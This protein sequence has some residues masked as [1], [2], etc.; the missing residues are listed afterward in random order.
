MK[1]KKQASPIRKIKPMSELTHPPIW[2]VVVAAGVGSRMQADVPKQYLP[3]AG[4]SVLDVTL[5]RLLSFERASGV[6]LVLNPKD[7]LWSSSEFSGDSRVRRVDGGATRADSVLAGLSY[8]N[9]AIESSGSA[10]ALVHDAARPCVTEAKLKYLVESCLARA[11][12]GILAVPATDTVKRAN[13]DDTIAKTEARSE[14]W[15]A[16][17]P[18][19]FPAKELEDAIREALSQNAEITDEA[20]AMEFVSKPVHLIEDEHNN[21][22][23]TRPSDLALAEWI[24]LQQQKTHSV[25]PNR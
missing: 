9:S 24:I 11:E 20:S 23:I 6:V 2:F 18:Q 16:H 10:W 13:S 8:L 4:K 3:L 22:K 17:T 25:G 21:I 14:L 1:I 15:L 5:S 7:S 19:F 12:G